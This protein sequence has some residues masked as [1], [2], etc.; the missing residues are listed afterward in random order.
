MNSQLNFSLKSSNSFAIESTTPCLY[1]PESADDLRQL[2]ALGLTAF[3]IIGEGSNTLFLSDKAPVIIKPNFKGITVAEGDDA[4]IITAGSSENWHQLVSFCVEQGY[5]G[6]ENLA[7]IPGSV[8]AAPIQ[9]IG[10]YG[11]EVADFLESVCWYEFS[12]QKMHQFT[13]TACKFGYRDSIFKNSLKDQGVITQ[14]TLKLPKKWQAN[15]GYNGLNTLGNNVSALQVYQRVIEVRQSKL[16]DP[17]VKPNAGSF[18]KNPVVTNA[19]YQTLLQQYP[20]IPAYIQDNQQVKLAAGWLIEK[21][22][23]KGIIKN[24]VGVHNKQAL[25]LVNHNNGSGQ[26]IYQL[27]LEINKKVHQIFGVY[28]QPEVRLVS[29]SGVVDNGDFSG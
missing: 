15:I 6:I 11:V 20:D 16:P 8:G 17:K 13:R 10:A 9:N 7:L 21:A 4:Y 1:S 12:T 3:Y 2:S 26:D 28:L 25:V 19:Y 22:G 24:N 27:A 23:Y 29:E 14:V 18:F 5:S